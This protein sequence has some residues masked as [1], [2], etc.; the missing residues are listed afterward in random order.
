MSN[1][2]VITA[3][4]GDNTSTIADQDVIIFDNEATL[5]KSIDLISEVPLE[6]D[7][8]NMESAYCKLHNCCKFDYHKQA[9]RSIFTI[10]I[11]IKVSCCILYHSSVD[12]RTRKTWLYPDTWLF[13]EIS[14]PMKVSVS[15]RQNKLHTFRFDLVWKLQTRQIGVAHTQKLIWNCML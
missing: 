12:S 4:D 10:C 13:L 2:N 3:N 8:Q 7:D 5:F 1:V 15:L 9:N 6:T 11:T 14:W